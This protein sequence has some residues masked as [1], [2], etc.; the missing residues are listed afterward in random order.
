MDRE[1]DQDPRDFEVLMLNRD[2]LMTLQAI[3][4]FE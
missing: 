3:V 2:A 4:R 1:E